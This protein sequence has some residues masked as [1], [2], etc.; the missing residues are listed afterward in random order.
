MVTGFVTLQSDQTYHVID[1]VC[2]QEYSL[3]DCAA[4][5]RF[6]WLSSKLAEIDVC[7]PHSQYHRY[8]INP[9]P[10]YNCDQAGLSV[11]YT[12]AVPY[13]KDGL[14]FYNKYDLFFYSVD[15]VKCFECLLLDW[16]SY[17]YECDYRLISIKKKGKNK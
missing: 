3:Y 2:W 11:A 16:L 1:M 5:F 9:V 13:V 17:S 4:E 6:F 7:D 14:L 15:N 8:R 12:G 10:G